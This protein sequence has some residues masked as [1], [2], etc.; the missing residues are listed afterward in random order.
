MPLRICLL[1]SKGTP[2]WG[3]LT[4]PLHLDN[5][6]VALVV[7]SLVAPLDGEAPVGDEGAGEGASVLCA[8]GLDGAALPCVEAP[9]LY[10]AGGGCDWW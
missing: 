4:T 9:P 1:F 5:V 7:L 6:A 2:C 10:G 8:G 3:S